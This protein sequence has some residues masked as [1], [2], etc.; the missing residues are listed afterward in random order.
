M[1]VQVVVDS[2]GKLRNVAAESKFA[3]ERVVILVQKQ[4]YVGNDCG[5][6]ENIAVGSCIDVCIGQRECI[7]C[8]QHF[9]G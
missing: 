4:F 8:C 1:Y 3:K 6:R 7:V 2:Q 5:G 9:E